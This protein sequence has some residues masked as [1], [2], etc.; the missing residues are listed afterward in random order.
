MKLNVVSIEKELVRVQAEGEISAH[1]FTADGKNP[2]EVMLGARWA[3]HQ[4][5]V[6][7]RAV[8]FLDSSAIGWFMCSRREFERGGGMIVLHSIQPRVRQVLDLLR[9]GKAL[10]LADNEAAALRVVHAAKVGARAEPAVAPAVVPASAAPVPLKRA[11]SRRK[12]AKP[13]TGKARRGAKAA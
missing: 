6:D 8:P 3:S 1:D 2:F 10:P 7:L 11:P 5:V 13:A 12:D 4:V 9:V